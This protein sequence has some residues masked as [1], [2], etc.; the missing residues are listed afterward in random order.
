MHVHC[1]LILII[2]TSHHSQ[3]YSR[4]VDIHRNPPVF[5]RRRD[6]TAKRQSCH[7][8]EREGEEG[9]CPRQHCIHFEI[10]LYNSFIHND[11]KHFYQQKQ[12]L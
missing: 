12:E 8:A 2:I 3:H 11:A 5:E 4:Y 10:Q 1:S 6:K 9:I 7:H